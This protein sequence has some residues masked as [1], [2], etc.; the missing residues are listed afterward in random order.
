MLYPTSILLGFS[1]G[2]HLLAIDAWL[3]ATSRNHPNQT[4]HLSELWFGTN[5]FNT[6]C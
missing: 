2:T 5:T 3:H 4:I 6:T 1:T